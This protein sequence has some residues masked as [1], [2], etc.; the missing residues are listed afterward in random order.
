MSKNIVFQ[1]GADS[2]D[3]APNL[4]RKLL[5]AVWMLVA[6]VWP[7]LR[8]VLAFDVAIKFFLALILWSA[9]GEH[10]GLNFFLHFFLFSALTLYVAS[11]PKNFDS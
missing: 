6:M 11:A 5:L 10:A 4:F 3:P 9:P 2:E 8:F 1:Q 7:V